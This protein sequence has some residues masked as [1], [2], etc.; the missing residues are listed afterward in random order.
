ML[1]LDLYFWPEFI[2]CNDDSHLYNSNDSSPVVDILCDFILFL[3]A[4]CIFSLFY[5]SPNICYTLSILQSYRILYYELFLF[6]LGK[7][8][9][10]NFIDYSLYCILNH[11]E[12]PPNK[13]KSRRDPLSKT[14]SHPRTLSLSI[15]NNHPDNSSLS[16]TLKLSLNLPKM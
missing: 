3:F 14:P 11:F 9:V 2:I 4:I 1:P 13:R 12:C 6:C 8:K 10:S 5:Q 7:K 15:S 16:S